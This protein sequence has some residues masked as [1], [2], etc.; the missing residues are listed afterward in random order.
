MIESILKP[1]PFCGSEVIHLEIQWGVVGVVKC[2]GCKTNFV[3]P[4]NECET[5]QDL[6]NAWNRRATD[7]RAD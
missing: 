4:W 3:L 2:N 6:Y 5:K 7:E 1:C